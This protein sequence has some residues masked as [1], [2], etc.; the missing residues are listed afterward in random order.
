[1]EGGEE[2]E[3]PRIKLKLIL[4]CLNNW[5]HSRYGKAIL[6]GLFFK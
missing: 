1:M 4:L 5:C 2:F 3:D 6:D